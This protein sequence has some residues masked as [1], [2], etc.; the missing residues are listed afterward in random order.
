MEILKEMITL[1]LE[2]SQI[3]ALK[4]Q[5][6]ETKTNLTRLVEIAINEFLSKQPNQ[7]EM[8]KRHLEVLNINDTRE[9]TKLEM[10][11]CM[12]LSNSKRR[13]VKMLNDGIT[14]K[15]LEKLIKVWTKEAIANGVS[16]KDFL[17]NIKRGVSR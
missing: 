6:Q 9:Q 1:R 12:F 13:I 11:K 17:E 10:R 14:E 15:A 16:E 2:Q 5:A 7:N 4:E 3:L 8:I